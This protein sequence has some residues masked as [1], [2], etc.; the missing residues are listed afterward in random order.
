MAR[1]SGWIRPFQDF[2]KDLRIKSKEGGPGD[3]SGTSLVLWESQKRFLRYLAEGLDDGIRIFFFLKSRQLGVTTLSVAIDVFW[4]AVHPNTIGALVTENEQNRDV[5]R[6]RIRAYIE[7]FPPG[8]FG[9]EFYIIKGKDNVK[10]MSFSNGS[11][12]D[13]KVAGTRSKGSAWAEGEGYTLAHLTE[14]ASYAS[15]DALSSFEESFAQTN[16]NRLYIYESTAKGVGNVWHQRWKSGFDDP[17]TKRSHF[18][19]WWSSDVNTVQRNDPRFAE[20]GRAPRTREERDLIT[21][22]KSEYDFDVTPEQVAWYRWRRAT[23][24]GEDGM[25]FEQNQPWTASQSFVLTGFSFFQTREI[26]KKINFI[27]DN[28][29]QYAYV[30]YHY[31]LGSIFTDMKL[32]PVESKDPIEV[33]RLT[34]LR[35]WEEPV[36]GGRYV[37]GYDPAWGRT[38]HKDRNSIQVWRCFADCMV[39]VAEYA[40][41][42]VELKRCAWVLFHLAGAYRDCIINVELDGAGRTILMEFDTLRGMLQSGAYADRV[43]TR[44]WE[45]ALGWARWYLYHR[46]DSIGAGYLNCFQSSYSNKRDILHQMQGAFA[47]NELVI[48]STHL[49]REMHGVI[50]DGTT[51][52]APESSAED[53]KDDRVM[54]TALAVRAWIN[55]RRPE[56][57][58][59]GLTRA[60]VMAEESGETSK[61]TSRM[62]SMVRRFMQTQEERAMQQAELPTWREERGL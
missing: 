39:Q 56:M 35:V 24:S 10:S 61:V 8:Y 33:D 21:A 31:E 32:R 45:D 12:I 41:S 55:W 13:F 58:S 23:T 40:T 22:V 9:D 4:L 6:A 36:E 2:V 42:Q 60:M 37:I 47:T 1:E 25:M 53:S 43:R 14:I 38:D 34:E 57:L 19:G 28:P 62:N 50:V 52:G 11:R 3:R 54:A 15:S 27:Y 18:M 5:N 26:T 20:Y 48:N 46:A 59:L 16:P 29:E 51:I 49:L 17:L 44:D 7:S 30:P